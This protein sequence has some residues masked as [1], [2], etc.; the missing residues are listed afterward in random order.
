MEIRISKSAKTCSE[1]RRP[2]VHNEEVNSL[3]RI[4]D[5]TLVREDYCRNCWREGRTTDA[6]SAWAPRFYDPRVAEK[7]P[8]EVFSPLRRLFYEAAD[9]SDRRDIAKAYLAA[10]LLRRQKVFRLIKDTDD[11]DGEERVSLFSDRISDR[12]IEV[13]DPNLTDEELEEGR[14]RLMER[15][16][17]LEAPEGQPEAE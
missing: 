3:V 8:P 11:L 13:R 1:C 16:G 5:R 2:F 12:L 6:F 10:Q 4:Q 15:L 7:E 14:Q 17:Q 9:A